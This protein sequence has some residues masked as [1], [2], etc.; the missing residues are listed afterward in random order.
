MSA[1]SEVCPVQ[2]GQT[3]YN[4]RSIDT[5]NY[6]TS[7]D[8]E[9]IRGTFPNTSPTLSGQLTVR[10]NGGMVHAILVRNVSGQKL[11][12]GRAVVWAAGYE[13]RRVDRYARVTAE[14]VAGIVD[15]HYGPDGVPNG[16]LFWLIVK[17]QCLIKTPAVAGGWSFAV[18]DRLFATTAVVT[19]ATTGTTGGKPQPWTGNTW[20]IT[21]VTDGTAGKIASNH[22]AVCLTAK[23]TNQTE[24]D[25]LCEVCTYW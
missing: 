17:G 24:Q 6:G 15:D 10:R 16:D 5:N 8:L 23:T 2:R 3:W 13:G 11:Y 14:Q 1:S 20:T 7:V 18:G 9:G 25:M 22:F 12:P 4:G 21:Q 19:A